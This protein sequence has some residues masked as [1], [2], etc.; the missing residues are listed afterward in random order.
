MVDV[1]KVVFL[2]SSVFSCLLFQKG[3]DKFIVKHYAEPVTYTIDT[4]IET[5]KDSF[6]PALQTCLQSSSQ[7]LVKKLFSLDEEKKE[8]SSNGGVKVGSVV[9]GCVSVCTGGGWCVCGWWVVCVGR[10]VWM[11]DV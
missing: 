7:Q 4:W 9:G 5:N 8:E 10:C 11:V 6:V 1:S 2:M 3:L